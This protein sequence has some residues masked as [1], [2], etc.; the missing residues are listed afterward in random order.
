MEGAERYLLLALSL[1]VTRQRR[2]ARNEGEPDFFRA[3]REP[4]L[5]RFSYERDAFRCSLDGRRVEQFLASVLVI[6]SA[7]FVSPVR[8]LR[9]HLRLIRDQ[10]GMQEV[11]LSPLV[12]QSLTVAPDDGMYGVYSPLHVLYSAETGFF[13]PHRE[14]WHSYLAR[15]IGA[16]CSGT[17]AVQ[18]EDGAT[19]LRYD[20]PQLRVMLRLSGSGFELRASAAGST[21]FLADLRK[22]CLSGHMPEGVTA[23]LEAGDAVRIRGGAG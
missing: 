1:L 18:E 7:D 6:E 16:R 21:G 14:S 10:H 12:V 15:C 19:L 11:K 2:L 20:S 9:P 8:D 13:L 23:T 22:F 3:L 4:V 5:F 17:F